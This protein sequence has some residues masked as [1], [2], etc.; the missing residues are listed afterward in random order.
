M[1]LNTCLCLWKEEEEANE[2]LMKYIMLL[3]SFFSLSGIPLGLRITSTE[4]V[5]SEI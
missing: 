5:G 4:F 2:T 3:L 1:S